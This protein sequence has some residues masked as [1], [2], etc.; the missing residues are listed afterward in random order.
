MR[1]YLIFSVVSLVLFL[2]SVG[3]TTVSVAFP[4]IISELNAS[5]VLAGWVLSVYQLV[6]ISSM[7]VAAKMSETFGRRSTFMLCAALFTAGSALCAL[8][9]NVTLLIVFRVIQAVGGGGFLPSAASIVSDE[10]P[11]MRQR[12]IGLF[13]SIFPIGAIVGPNLGGWMVASLGWKSIFWFNVPLGIIVLILSKLLLRPSSGNGARGIDFVG[14]GLLVGFISA[15]M[16][17]LTE[18]GN[19]DSGVSLLIVSLLVVLSIIILIAFLIWER[20]VAEP[21]INLKLI[22]ARPFLETNIY[23]LIYGACAFGIFSFI[24]LYAVSIY[25]MSIF[26]SGLILTPRSV[27]MMVASTVTSLFLIRWGYRWPILVGTLIV[28]LSLFLLSSESLGI[29]ISGVQLSSTILLLIIMAI[30]GIGIGISA[31]AAN[32]ACI[33][34]MPDNVATI[35]GLRGMFRQMGGAISITVTTLLL[36][37]LGDMPYAFHVTFIS[38]GLIMLISIPAIFVMPS[39]PNMK[40]GNHKT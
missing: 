36:H 40:V 10:F 23:N 26:Q 14:A 9:P 28:V 27:G 22:L 13:T 5:L 31:P 35:T 21:L 1:R 15:F 7:P 3:A 37:S 20:R 33:E 16:V 11:E 25:N 2:A 39:S 19:T 30:S 6:A 29:N 24:P 34:L 38:L 17:A 8:A 32:N 4:V 18:L 12:A